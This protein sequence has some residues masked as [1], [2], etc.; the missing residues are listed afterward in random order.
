MNESK[1][2]QE[3]KVA[4]EIRL[5]TAEVFI[6]VIREWN[7]NAKESLLLVLSKD[8]YLQ[9]GYDV[10]FESL[11]LDF[12]PYRSHFLINVFTGLLK[13]RLGRYLLQVWC[14]RFT[15]YTQNL[16]LRIP[17]V[18]LWLLFPLINIR[19]LLFSDFSGF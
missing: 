14:R 16:M 19:L 1:S 5:Q 18:R 17:I 13:R 15:K 7:S 3:V 9:S 4:V 11:L 2:F 8:Q 12:H 10:S 6:I